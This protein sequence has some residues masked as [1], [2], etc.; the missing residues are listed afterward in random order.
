M[1]KTAF[2]NNPTPSRGGDYQYTDGRFCRVTIRE[3]TFDSDSVYYKATAYQV[4]ASGAWVIGQSG[5]PKSTAESTHTVAKS[6]IS[7]GA[8]TVDACLEAI[9]TAKANELLSQIGPISG[10][11]QF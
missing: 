10:A 1:I 6:G 4:D 5:A 9:R 3:P 2:A 7:A 8:Y 11:T